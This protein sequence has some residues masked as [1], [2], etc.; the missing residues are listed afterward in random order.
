MKQFYTLA[1]MT[2]NTTELHGA[3]HS[4]G[5]EERPMEFADRIAIYWLD[6]YM[7]DLK[8]SKST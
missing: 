2:A 6:S 4:H 8:G 5:C 7:P 3:R 1:E